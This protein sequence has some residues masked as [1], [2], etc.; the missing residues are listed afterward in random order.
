MQFLVYILVYPFIWLISI[1]PFQLLYALSDGLY[2]IIYKLVGYRKKVVQDNLRLVFPEKPETEINDI[3][4]KFYHHFCDMMVEAIKS[5][6]ISEESM[7]ERLTFTNVEL[8]TNLGKQNRSI[9]LMCGHYGSWEWIFILQ[10]YLEHKGYAVYSRLSNK[11][12]DRLVKRIRAKYNSTLITTKETVPTL[13]KSKLDGELTINGFV[14]DQSP[15]VERAYHWNEFMGIK[16]PIHTG[17]EMLAKR[18]DMS[19]VFFRVKRLKRGYY[20]TTFEMLAHDPNE[21]PNYEISDMFT[22]KVEKQ[23]REAPQY[24]LWTHR[25]WKHRDKVPAE[26]Q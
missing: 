24:Y 13:T 17:A 9:I 6:T 2:I 16:V 21:Y 4:E 23:I 20:E 10:T 12:F 22:K 5:L 19:V 18:L 25:R 3:T 1:L 15:Q 8:L 14:S 26:F 11:Y 7:K